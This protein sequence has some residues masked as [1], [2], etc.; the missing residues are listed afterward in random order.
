MPLDSSRSDSPRKL[1]LMFL[2]TLIVEMNFIGSSDGNGGVD[3]N[4]RDCNPD[5]LLIIS[6][7]LS[8]FCL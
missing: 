1:I 6:F 5:D 8:D 4:I 3:R 2:T 7:E